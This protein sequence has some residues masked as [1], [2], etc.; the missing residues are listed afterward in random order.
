MKER[1]IQFNEKEAVAING[2]LLENSM[3]MVELVN[4]QN[5]QEDFDRAIKI[6]HGAVFAQQTFFKQCFNGTFEFEEN[7]YLF[8]RNVVETCLESIKAAKE[9]LQEA[10]DLNSINY[11][12]E[13][14][15]LRRIL[16]KIP[17]KSLILT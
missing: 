8:Y 3:K 6:M 1:K 15:K 4:N 14:E 5:N 16:E 11:D 17:E 9:A 10:G 12:E 2:I 7:V 13:I